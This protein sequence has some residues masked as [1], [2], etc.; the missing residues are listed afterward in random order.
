[1]K[2]LVIT[3]SPTVIA[4]SPSEKE[5]DEVVV[6][7]Y[8]TQRRQDLTGSIAKIDAAEVNKI[9]VASFDAQLQGKAPGVQVLTNSGVPGE[10]IF[11]RVR[12]TTSIN[13]SSDPLYIVDGVFLNN[14][15]LQNISLAGR[16]TSPLADI[17]PG[18]IESI[19]VLK[20]AAATAIY[21][22]RG[23][24]GV[25]IITTK[26]GNYGAKTK[27]DIDASN[28]WVQADKSLLPPLATG[29][30]VAELANE[31]TINS[32]I[33]Q[34]RTYDY[35][36][37]R[38]PFRPVSEVVD[39]VAGRGTPE[40]TPT[41]DR[42]GLLLRKGHIQ[43]YNL[44]ITGGGNDSRYYL[45]AGYTGQQ[46]YLKVLEFQRASLKFNFDQKLSERVKI[47]LTN[48][49]S[50]SYRNQARTGDGPQAQLYNSAIATAVYTP[51]YTDEGIPS[52]TN[53]TIDLI[54]NYDINTVSLRY[55][56]SAFAEADLAK[57]L[58]LR[59]SLSLDYNIY[60]ET[61]YWNTNT[62]LGSGDPPG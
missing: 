59:S 42:L 54:N 1:N 52:G 14:T 26:Q 61:E 8:G 36:Y 39:G 17:N 53:N 50:R 34:G 22:S 33:D 57:G 10:A 51:I 18:D 7:G 49:F 40:E 56:G 19:E 25:V 55:V 23:A 45:G 5:L 16:V 13:S 24:N 4:L 35:A 20:D 27:I 43:D 2:K 60:D 46:A 62:V 31:W 6:V 30:E 29:P 28:G 21:G 9:P 48:S 15:S 11:L 32:L 12:G 44:G 3:N 58:K 41:Y 47:G 38:R 37:A